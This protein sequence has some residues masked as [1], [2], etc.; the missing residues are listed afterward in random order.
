ML[1]RC[2]RE[3]LGSNGSSDTP[4]AGRYDRWSLCHSTNPSEFPVKREGRVWMNMPCRSLTGA[5]VRNVTP[6]SLWIAAYSMI[7]GVVNTRVS[8]R[9][10]GSFFATGAALNG[11]NGFQPPVLER[12]RSEAEP[13]RERRY[14][15]DDGSKNASADT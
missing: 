6:R 4:E 1:P 13:V 8:S 9:V 11:S 15:D 2:R 14:V 10:S 5:S 7:S 12:R 3:G